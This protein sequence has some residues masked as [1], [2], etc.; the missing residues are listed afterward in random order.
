MSLFERFK[1]WLSNFFDRRNHFPS[2][3]ELAATEPPPELAGCDF[4]EFET[5][6]PIIREQRP[7]N[8]R[9][10]DEVQRDKKLQRK[11]PR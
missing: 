8:P 3:A 5:T 4:G 1:I 11:G 6:R 9:R 2:D 10:Y 7:D